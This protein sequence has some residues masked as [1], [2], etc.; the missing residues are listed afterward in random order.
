MGENTINIMAKIYFTCLQKKLIDLLLTT[1]NGI[2]TI[3][4]KN[5]QYQA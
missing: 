3:F 2:T 1:L 4:T 5:E